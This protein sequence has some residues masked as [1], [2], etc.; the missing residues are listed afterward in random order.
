MYMTVAG[1][2]V[3]TVVMLS[4]MFLRN[5]FF[6]GGGRYRS[7][8]RGKGNG[9]MIMLVFAIVL[10]IIAPILV[11]LLYFALSRRR[12]YL[13]DAGGAVYTRYPEGLAS[14]LEAIHEDP[15]V[16]ETANR[17]TAPMYIINPFNKAG[18]W[19]MSLTA[20]H[21]PVE[22]RIAVLRGMSG[23]SYKNYESAYAN[24]VGGH[25]MPD[26]ALKAGEGVAPRVASAGAAPLEPA[27]AMQTQ[28]RQMRD[29]G[30][31]VRKVQNFTFLTC[32]CG[33]KIKLPP[34]MAAG[35]VECPRCHRP[36]TTPMAE[37]TPQEDGG[38]PLSVVKASSGWTTIRC[39]CGATKNLPPSFIAPHVTCANC[40]R[41]ITVRDA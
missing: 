36:L 17:E 3:G 16:L 8:D 15:A 32:A 31:L 14:A 27:A 40:G 35:R 25:V 11:Q 6:A 7:D 5:L 13:A 33:M 38:A 1:I 39:T 22:K 9:Q 10:A 28:R 29:A 21:P 12:E 2:M 4:D 26:S 23:A 30:D 37:P 24:A 18:Q 20:T 34:N 41:E 19:A